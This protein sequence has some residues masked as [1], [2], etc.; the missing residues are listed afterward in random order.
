MPTCYILICKEG[1]KSITEDSKEGWRACRSV[2][3]LSS[4]TADKESLQHRRINVGRANPMHGGI[5]M[6]YM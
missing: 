4:R 5:N 6:N 2:Y 1:T 3:E